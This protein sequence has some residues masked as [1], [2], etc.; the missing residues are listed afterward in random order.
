M[1]DLVTFSERF[2]LRDINSHI[3]FN[4]LLVNALETQEIKQKWFNLTFTN[5]LIRSGY[6]TVP[7]KLHYT[8]FLFFL[9]ITYISKI[10]VLFIANLI[11]IT[12]IP[13]K[14]S[15]DY[16]AA[17]KYEFV[18]SNWTN[19][20]IYTLRFSNFTLYVFIKTILKLSLFEE[21]YKIQYKST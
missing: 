3:S 9:Y 13:E 7:F 8:H 6:Q 20:Q 16:I 15:N 11:F 1:K 5:T 2:V 4:N 21:I 17:K 18:I 12:I 19:L 14:N 10:Y